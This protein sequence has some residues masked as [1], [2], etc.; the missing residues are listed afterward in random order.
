MSE[1][2]GLVLNIGMIALL[3]VTIWWAARLNRSL[4]KMRDSRSDM[5]AAILRFS[6]AAARAETA[7]RT[8]KTASAEHGEGLTREA[9][10][11]RLLLEELKDL[12]EISSGTAARLEKAVAGVSAAQIGAALSPKPTA[13]ARAAAPEAPASR[14]R[15]ER[16]LIEAL[17]REAAQ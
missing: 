15:A 1:I 10:R 7:I 3:A 8:L 2:L 16:E 13:P 17:L 12:N 11:A 4:G 6:D 14:S 9:E 5:E